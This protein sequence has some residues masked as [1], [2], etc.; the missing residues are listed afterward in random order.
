[1]QYIVLF[2]SPFLSVGHLT[3]TIPSLDGSTHNAFALW[4]PAPFFCIMVAVTTY[5]LQVV[6]ANKLKVS[7][8]SWFSRHRSYR[9]RVERLLSERTWT[10]QSERGEWVPVCEWILVSRECD[11]KLTMVFL[12]LLVPPCTF[13]ILYRSTGRLVSRYSLRVS[14]WFR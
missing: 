9:V 6:R 10:R 8:V 2:P 13:R 1:M 3:V 7:K 5:L 4:T 14:K 11:G 12:S